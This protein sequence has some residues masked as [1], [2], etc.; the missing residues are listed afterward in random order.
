MEV[1]EKIQETLQTYRFTVHSG[2]ETSTG[3]KFKGIN[4]EWKQERI[5]KRLNRR[6]KKE[7]INKQK[8]EKKWQKEFMKQQKKKYD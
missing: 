7:K 2:R 6:Q 5:I 4:N 8:C 3:R 1:T